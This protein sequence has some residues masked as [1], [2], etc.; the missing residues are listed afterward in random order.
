MVF[1]AV[2][3]FLLF[4]CSR[5]S[6]LTFELED[7][8][9]QC[10]FNWL[11]KGSFCEVDYQVIS[12]GNYDV[13]VIT[14]DPKGRIIFRK[15]RSSY[16]TF[17]LNN[18]LDGEYKIC[19]SNDFSS[20]THKVVFLGWFDSSETEPSDSGLDM[21]LQFHHT[22]KSISRNLVATEKIQ[23]RERLLSSVSHSFA[24]QLNTRVMYW[25]IGLSV[26][27]VAVSLVQVCILRSFFKVPSSHHITIGQTRVSVPPKFAH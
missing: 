8:T 20:V 1:S 9:T 11:K 13:D 19:F 3:V 25:S 26:L 22:L 4:S 24:A 2:L 18:T 7:R 12:G 14:Y 5:A 17:R 21:S 15:D 16:Y 23:L 6:I 27:V 10:Y